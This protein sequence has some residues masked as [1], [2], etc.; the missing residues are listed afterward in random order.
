MTI[1]TKYEKDNIVFYL[2]DGKIEK[3]TIRNIDIAVDYFK[4]AHSTYRL[5]EDTNKLDKVYDEGELFKNETDLVLDLLDT[6]T[7]KDY[8]NAIL[9]KDLC[10]Y[11]TKHSDK[12]LTEFIL[13]KDHSDGKE[14]NRFYI[15]PKGQD[16]DIIILNFASE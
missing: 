15:R 16:G 2:K 7:I 6:D 5:E 10:Q 1:Q 8:Q 11:M 3:G 4:V 12:G 9:W 13:Y 14:G